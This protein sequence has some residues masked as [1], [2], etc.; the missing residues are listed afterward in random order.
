M[1]L[2]SYPDSPLRH[3]RPALFPLV[4]SDPIFVPE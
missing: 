1:D 4:P 3:V 2:L